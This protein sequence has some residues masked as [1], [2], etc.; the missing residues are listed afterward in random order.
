MIW[1]P[2]NSEH[3][4]S[5]Q[6]HKDCFPSLHDYLHPEKPDKVAKTVN[7]DQ[8]KRFAYWYNEFISTKATQEQQW[9]KLGEH[10][11]FYSSKQYVLWLAKDSAMQ[12]LPQYVHQ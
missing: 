4:N 8:R 9:D 6:T 7:S 2:D 1:H 11:S 12:Q 5:H 3:C 10:I